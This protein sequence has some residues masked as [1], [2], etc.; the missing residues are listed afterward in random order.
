MAGKKR[1]LIILGSYSSFFPFSFP[2][3]YEY[4]IFFLEGGGVIEP[5]NEY[6]GAQACEF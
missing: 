5:S 6:R 3:W 1:A 2:T 4:V